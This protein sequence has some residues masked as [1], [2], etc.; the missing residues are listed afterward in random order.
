MVS[1]LF[2]NWIAKIRIY[3]YI[4][5]H[6]IIYIHIKLTIN[7]DIGIFPLLQQGIRLPTTQTTEFQGNRP[8]CSE[9]YGVI[10]P[11]DKRRG[12][13]QKWIQMERRR[14]VLYRIVIYQDAWIYDEVDDW[15]LIF[16]N[17]MW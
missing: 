3:I 12:C 6:I 16:C 8:T 4:Y 5:I 13:K 7:Y 17:E 2:K 15:C 10:G 14:Y 11:I 1:W 9:F